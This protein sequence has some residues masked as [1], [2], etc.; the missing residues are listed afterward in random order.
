MADVFMSSELMFFTWSALISSIFFSIVF[1]GSNLSD[2]IFSTNSVVETHF[3]IR[4]SNKL[5]YL[6][7]CFSCSM[8]FDKKELLVILAL[9]FLQKRV[10]VFPNFRGTSSIPI[11]LNSSCCFY[12]NYFKSSYSFKNIWSDLSNMDWSSVSK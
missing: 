12:F 3:Q 1:S 6:Y 11:L 7:K 8:I 2:C 5:E 9:F 4:F 10:T